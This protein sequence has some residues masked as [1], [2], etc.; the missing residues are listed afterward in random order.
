M[1]VRGGMHPLA[2]ARLGRNVCLQTRLISQQPNPLLAVLTCTK[3]LSA[4]LMPR[5]R[6][7]MANLATAAMPR[8]RPPTRAVMGVN[9][10]V[11]VATAAAGAKGGGHTQ[12]L[13]S[14]WRKEQ[15]P[16]HNSSRCRL[17]PTPPAAHLLPRTSE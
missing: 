10:M 12:R 14:K 9:C 8:V 3:P 1:S 13:S 16:I 15:H 11:V 6:P 4:P 2:S 5:T 7:V 17:C